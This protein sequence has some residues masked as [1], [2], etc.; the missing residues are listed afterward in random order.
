MC[1]ER[2]PNP[3]KDAQSAF[4]HG[5]T[6]LF[7]RTLKSFEQFCKRSF[8]IDLHLQVEQG[9]GINSKEASKISISSY[10]GITDNTGAKVS[11]KIVKATIW[12]HPHCSRPFARFLIGHELYHLLLELR[13]MHGLYNED[14]T[15]DKEEDMCNTFG[16][17]L[18]TDYQKLHHCP[19]KIRKYMLF[20][21]DVFSKFSKE[22]IAT[23]LQNDSLFSINPEHSWLKSCT[24]EEIM[25][26]CDHQRPL[27]CL[28]ANCPD[29]Q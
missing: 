21:P 23:L 25:G 4:A 10:E 1:S 16:V 2:K 19:A 11:V 26:T 14:E 28:N 7:P 22:N 29:K 24:Y 3:V 9:R 6:C 27:P 8:N 17:S 18:C 15:S 5:I 20:P 13:K 12:I